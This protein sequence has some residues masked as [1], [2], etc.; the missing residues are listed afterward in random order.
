MTNSVEQDSSVL[1]TLAAPAPL[2]TGEAA[3][4][5]SLGVSLGTFR[6]WVA[7]GQIAA[8]VLPSGIVRKLYRVADLERFAASLA[9]KS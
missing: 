7:D 2:L 1:K 3:A 6:R 9:A 5:E 4:A 8:V